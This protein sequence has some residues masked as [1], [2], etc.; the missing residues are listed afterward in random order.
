MYWYVIVQPDLLIVPAAA[1]GA[2]EAVRNARAALA[3][4]TPSSDTTAFDG[5]KEVRGTEWQ[6]L[7][8]V[9]YEVAFTQC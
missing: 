1:A 4:L 6:W 2:D 7:V 9:K 8:G 5:G 3:A